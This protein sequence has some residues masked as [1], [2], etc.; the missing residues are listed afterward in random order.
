[1][2]DFRSVRLLGSL[3]VLGAVV[4]CSTPAQAPRDPDGARGEGQHSTVADL[5]QWAQ[6]ELLQLTPNLRIEMLTPRAIEWTTADRDAK[7][8]GA[9]ASSVA[10]A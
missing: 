4:G 10:D 2:A 7:R 3:I 9:E 6:S 1:M 5:V 8:L